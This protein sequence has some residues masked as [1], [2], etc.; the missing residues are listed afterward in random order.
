MHRLGYD[1]TLGCTEELSFAQVFN[2]FYSFNEE[3]TEACMLI[4]VNM[5][6]CKDK[7]ETEQAS[8]H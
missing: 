6:G 3:S 2:N 7:E 5:H 1:S 4:C 8:C